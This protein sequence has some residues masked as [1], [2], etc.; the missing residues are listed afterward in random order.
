MHYVYT[1]VHVIIHTYIIH[2]W[3]GF[4]SLYFQNFLDRILLKELKRTVDSVPVC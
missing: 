3:E 2:I 4:Y 1:H